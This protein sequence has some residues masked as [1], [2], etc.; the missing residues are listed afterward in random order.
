MALFDA[1][2]FVLPNSITYRASAA[3]AD[4]A[5]M[6]VRTSAD[7]DRWQEIKIIASLA[8]SDEPSQQLRPGTF[9]NKSCPR[10]EHL[11]LRRGQLQREQRQIL[12]GGS[13]VADL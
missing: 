8:S 1:A 12:S 6:L 4:S 11:N 2:A 5:G 3:A 9:L 7:Q 13:A 10:F